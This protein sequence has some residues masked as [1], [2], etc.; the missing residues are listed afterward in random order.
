MTFTRKEKKKKNP[1]IQCGTSLGPPGYESHTLP[2]NQAGPRLLD[3]MDFMNTELYSTHVVK[4]DKGITSFFVFF[5]IPHLS[6]LSNAVA[7]LCYL[8]FALLVLFNC[9]LNDQGVEIHYRFISIYI[10]EYIMI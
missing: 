2:Q 9:V 10:Y 8:H 6:C 7:H 5:P 4:S 1:R 3:K